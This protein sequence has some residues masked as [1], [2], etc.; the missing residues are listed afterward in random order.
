MRDWR[1]A[2]IFAGT[3]QACGPASSPPA[4]T[5]ETPEPSEASARTI[6]DLA[7][8]IAAQLARGD[9]EA[10]TA[11][12]DDTMRS[13]L[14]V[15]QLTQVWASLETQL[16]AFDRIGITRRR[17]VQGLDVVLVRMAF[18]RG[19]VDL[20]IVFDAEERIAGLFVVPPTDEHA[21]EPPAYARLDAIEE[22]E[23][24]IGADP[25][26]LP[27][28]LTLPREGRPTP[29][30]VLIH[31]SGPHDRDQTLGPNKPFRDLA[32][33]LASRGVAVLRFE[34]R[35]KHHGAALQAKVGE[36][37]TL[38]H[39]SVEDALAAVE[40][41]KSTGEVDRNRIFV[42]GHSA[43]GTAIPR[44][45]RRGP[46]IRGFVIMA[47]S[48]QPLED[49]VYRQME[50]IAKLD[51]KLGEKEQAILAQVKAQVAR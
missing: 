21:Y 40:L 50:Y 25:W 11:R 39:E 5:P 9:A 35:T 18:A 32:L 49:I 36:R 13:A 38:D 46:S 41:L 12:F 24:T 42:L 19:E 4:S 28:T 30:L 2:M 47:G 44:I 45:A 20:K 1:K 48:T 29:A 7:R 34:K 22:R 15:A 31:G 17:R 51:G 16:G 3:L 27:G 26:R 43:G 8:D 23:I 6:E 10:V 14:P 37:I 33:G